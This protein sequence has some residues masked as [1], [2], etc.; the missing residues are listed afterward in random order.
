MDRLLILRNDVK[1]EKEVQQVKI[2]IL[3]LSNL[4]YKVLDAHKKGGG[5]VGSILH[6]I[7]TFTITMMTFV[8]FE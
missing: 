2:N 6:Y 3:K 4:Y 1:H 7:I 8:Y 5:K